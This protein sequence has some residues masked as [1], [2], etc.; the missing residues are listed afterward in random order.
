[1]SR[2]PR[3]LPLVVLWGSSLL[4]SRITAELQTCSP[5]NRPSSRCPS[6][7]FPLQSK[8]KPEQSCYDPFLLLFLPFFYGF[9]L[10]RAFQKLGSLLFALH[11]S[12]SFFTFARFGHGFVFIILY[13]FNVLHA[14]PH[15]KSIIS[16]YPELS[17]AMSSRNPSRAVNSLARLETEVGFRIHSIQSGET[18]K[19]LIARLF[20]YN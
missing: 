19:A 10:L 12:T 3:S 20:R 1:M 14:F 2:T 9:W 11:L 17:T 15:F 6:S 16:S 5:A 8:R 4:L 13:L 7:P 18:A